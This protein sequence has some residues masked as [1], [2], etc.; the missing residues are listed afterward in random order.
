MNVI[1]KSLAISLLLV[2]SLFSQSVFGQ[3]DEVGK[4]NSQF[5]YSGTLGA[6]ERIELNIQIQD[7]LITGSCILPQSSNLYILKGRL[8]ADQAGMGLLVYNDKNEYIASIDAKIKSDE[9]NYLKEI[10]GVWKLADGKLTKT[11]Y[12]AKV[13]ELAF[14]DNDIE[15]YYSYY[16]PNL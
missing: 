4:R 14:L 6:S 11:L 5:Y 15:R 9:F 10:N 3:V 7:Q 12:L 8:S 2:L 13:A 16:P 1:F